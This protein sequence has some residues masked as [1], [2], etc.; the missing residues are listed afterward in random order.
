MTPARDNQPTRRLLT[1]RLG[2][3]YVVE[4][5]RS[6]LSIRPKGSRSGR[7][8]VQLEI[9]SLFLRSLSAKVEAEARERRRSHRRKGS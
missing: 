6:H 3:S 1:S 4:L 7:I 8:Q 5:Y 2:D 9:G